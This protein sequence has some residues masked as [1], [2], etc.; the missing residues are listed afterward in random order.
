MWV[1]TVAY[2]AETT[3]AAAGN[4]TVATRLCPASAADPGAGARFRPASFRASSK[5]P[6]PPTTMMVRMVVVLVVVG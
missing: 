6:G 1:A 3:P 4:G 5:R 2:A